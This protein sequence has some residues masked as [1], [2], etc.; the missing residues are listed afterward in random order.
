MTA[1]RF[2]LDALLEATGT[3]TPAELARLTRWHPGTIGRWAVEGVPW[4]ASDQIA[5]AAGLHPALVWPEWAEY[6]LW[7]ATHAPVC[8]D[9]SRSR[10]NAGRCS[11]P[12]CME[13]ARDYY[14]EYRTRRARRAGEAVA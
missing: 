2:Q 9:P 5:V 10:F 8:D 11:C 6:A 3:E 12:G 14:T 1:P 4:L 13:R 7:E